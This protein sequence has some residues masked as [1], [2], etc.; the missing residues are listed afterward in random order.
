MT[1]VI[2]R[3]AKQ[4]QYLANLNVPQAQWPADAE[5]ASRMIDATIAK[6]ETEP[7]TPAQIGLLSANS[8]YSKFLAGVGKR[9]A[10][11]MCLILKT[12]AEYEAEEDP[13]MKQVALLRLYS[14]LKTRLVDPAKVAKKQAALEQLRATAAEPV[15]AAD[16]ETAPF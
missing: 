10:S 16:M 11:T 1:N 13:A 6:R 8:I 9:E 4:S 12:I 7:A 3:T 15:T 5:G 2:A 14:D